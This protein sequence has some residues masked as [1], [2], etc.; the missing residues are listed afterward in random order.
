MA[1]EYRF[2]FKRLDVYQAAVRHF[3]WTVGA[4]SR[5]PRGPFVIP[6]QMVGASLSI[7]GNVAEANGRE[8][9]P[10]EAEQHYRYARGSA[11]EAASH[12]DALAA[13]DAIDDD[14]YNAQEAHLA[15]I[16]AMLTRLMQNERGRRR[17]KGEPDGARAPGWR[18][19]KPGAAMEQ[20]GPKGQSV[21]KQGSA[22]TAAAKSPRPQDAASK[23][24]G[25]QAGASNLA[26][27]RS[28]DRP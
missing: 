10:G 16:A 5:L 24:S 17:N 3:G 8:T 21:E 11:F 9:E 12:L 25:R 28:Q 22:A 27:P 14:D 4:V 1:K 2:R 15:R 23:S 13:L 6:N 20:R 7:L 18:A 26:P 19:A